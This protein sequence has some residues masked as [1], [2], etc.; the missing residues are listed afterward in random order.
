MKE[1]VGIKVNCDNLQGLANSHCSGNVSMLAS[2]I[3]DFFESVTKDFP[4]R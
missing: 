2:E 1:L 3:S 4:P